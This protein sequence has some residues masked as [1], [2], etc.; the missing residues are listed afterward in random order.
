VESVQVEVRNDTYPDGTR[1]INARN[2]VISTGLLPRMPASIE[3]DERVWHSS[4]FLEKF[5]Q[6]DRGELR[7][8]AVVGAGQS[9]AEIVRFLYDELPGATIFAI[10]PS[11]GYSIA[12]NTPYANQVFDASAV[13]EYYYGTEQSKDAFWRYH[14]NTNYS[15]VEP[16]VIWD[17]YRRAYDEEVSRKKRLHLV[18]LTMIDAVKRAADETRITVNSLLADESYDVDVDVLVCATGYDPMQPT[19]LLHDLDGLLVRDGQGRYQIERDYSL[20]T[21][22][23]LCCGIYLQGGTERTHGLSSSLLSNIAV[24]SGEI[25]N[26]IAVRLARER[27]RVSKWAE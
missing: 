20:I 7:R 16:E 11:Y 27:L 10:I 22:P 19:D 23:D 3:R 15:V 4:E 12:D 8:V 2:L 17:L 14:R 26:S 18:K 5:H 24:R 25:A 13:D 6:L 21:M 9:A 1:L